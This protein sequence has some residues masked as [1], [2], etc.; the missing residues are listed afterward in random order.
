MT[1]T[2]KPT[3]GNPHTRRQDWRPKWEKMKTEA[4]QE[5]WRYQMQNPG[6]RVYLYYE[7]SQGRTWGK[8]YAVPEG[9]TTQQPP[10]IVPACP[11]TAPADTMQAI[12]SWIDKFAG[13]L[14]MLGE[15]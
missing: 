14:P 4:A 6:S 3:Q 13:A 5:L 7:P 11:T 10:G 2:K 8:F 12:R 1:R 15:S 9:E